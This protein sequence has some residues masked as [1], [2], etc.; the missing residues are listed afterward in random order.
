[1]SR[2]VVLGATG[3]VGG[4][5]VPR[6]ASAGHEVIAVSRGISKPYREHPAWK[7]VRRVTL[8]RDEGDAA[9]TFAGAIADLRADIVIDMVCFASD[10]ADQLI[11][12][13]RGRIEL[14]LSCGTIWVHGPGAEVPTRED[15]ARNPFGDYGTQKARIEELLLAESHRPG[16]LQSSVLH[17]GHITGPGWA[18]VNAAGN[19]DLDV[20][21]RLAT[22]QSVAIPNLGLET[23]HHVHADDVAQAFQLALERPEA[24]AGS[25]YHVVSERALTLR[26]IATAAAG[27][28]GRDADLRYLP[29]EDF[30]TATSSINAEATYDHISRSPSM[31]I[32]KAKRELGYA[33]KYSSLQAI[34]E[35]LQWLISDGQLEVRGRVLDSRLRR[36]SVAGPLWK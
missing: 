10:S 5:L 7:D 25:S 1:M 6:L 36:G 32:D 9:G 23:V 4:Y 33:P 17:P 34:A 13:L 31:S 2:V 26:G 35:G 28:F 15:D 29:F 21:H 30:K 20:W 27:W 16:G 19:F 22:G 18:M 14:L 11:E 12:A 8:D 3:H 24:S